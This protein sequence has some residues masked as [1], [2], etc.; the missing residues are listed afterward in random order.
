MTDRG[1]L[2]L[3][4]REVLAKI[5]HDLRHLQP[6]GLGFALLVFDLGEGG[7]LAYVS[8]ARRE[9][10]VRAMLEFCQ[11]ALGGDLRSV[12]EQERKT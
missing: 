1:T 6:A 11:K 10:M 7:N 2:E 12:F 9:D 4:C 8:N 5:G 3:A